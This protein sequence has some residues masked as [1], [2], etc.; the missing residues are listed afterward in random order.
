MSPCLTIKDLVELSQE[1]VRRTTEKA[2]SLD[3][4]EP[5][6][7]AVFGQQ[8]KSL[9][10]SLVSTYRLGAHLA[11]RA[12][13]VE[14]LAEIWNAVSLA[15]DE[16]LRALKTLKNDYP[17]CGTPELYDLALDYK[18][19]ASKRHQLNREAMEWKNAPMPPGLFPEPN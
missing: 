19:A 16:I 6:A 5:A 9:H 11:K 18:N 10:A 8:V 14:T 15:C 1:E 7:G 2:A 13:D 4:K 12:E 17:L 3:P